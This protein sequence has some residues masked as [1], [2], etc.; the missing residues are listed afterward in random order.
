MRALRPVKEPF[1]QKV[2]DILKTYPQRDGYI[3]NLFRVFAN[4]TR[5]LR[6]GVANLLDKDSPLPLRLREIVILR[7][8][9]NLDCEYEWGVHVAV[10]SKAAGLTEDQIRAIRFGDHTFGCWSVREGLLI[11]IIDE[12]CVAGTLGEPA[13]DQFEQVWTSEQQLEI[14]ALCGNYHTICY[15]ANVAR[16]DGE[17]FASKFPHARSNSQRKNVDTA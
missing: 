13:R 8:T 14:L 2:A 10:F 7:V 3:L 17:A 4:S 1:S 15:V 16:L 9:S 5:F 6:K 12:L 11:K